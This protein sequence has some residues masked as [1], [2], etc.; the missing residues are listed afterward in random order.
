MYGC[1]IFDDYTSRRYNEALD[2]HSE[3]ISKCSK[4]NLTE[5]NL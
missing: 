3:C 4:I 1:N 5:M 2:K